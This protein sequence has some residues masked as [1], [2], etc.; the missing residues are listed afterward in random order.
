MVLHA[1]DASVIR[2]CTDERLLRSLSKVKRHTAVVSTGPLGSELWEPFRGF[3]TAFGL[4]SSLPVRP[5]SD[6]HRGRR[7]VYDLSPRNNDDY[8]RAGA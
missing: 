5:T 2:Y 1:G 8:H 3:I 6:R 4:A 7:H